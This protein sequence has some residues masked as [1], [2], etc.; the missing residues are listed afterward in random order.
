MHAYMDAWQV[1][2]QQHTQGALIEMLGGFL[3]GH[4]WQ[5]LDGLDSKRWYGT[6]MHERWT[7]GPPYPASSLFPLPCHQSTLEL[8]FYRFK[9]VLSPVTLRGFMRKDVLLL[10]GGG[11]QVHGRHLYEECMEK[12]GCMAN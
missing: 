5:S 7:L 1:A 6:P 11:G 3:R 9:G 4:S 12:A 10:N 8:D 2:L